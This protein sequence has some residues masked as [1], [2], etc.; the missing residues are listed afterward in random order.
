MPATKTASLYDAVESLEFY[1]DRYKKGYMNDWPA[2]K[3]RKV[4]EVIRDLPLPETGDA[5]DFG[6]GMGIFTDIIRQ[7]LPGWNLYGTD[8]S[9]VAV[10]TALERFDQCT[11]FA[12]DDPAFSGKRFDFA[13]S[14][15]VFEHVFD[16][17]EVFDELNG[18]LKPQASMLHF[19]PCGNEGSLEHR[20][21]KLRVDGIDAKL[22]NR[23]F[24]EDEGHVRRLTTDQF[25]ELCDSAG[26][27]LQREYYSNHHDGAIEWI[28]NS[29]PKLI[30]EIC[31]PSH[32]VDSDAASELAKMK[33]Y[34]LSVNLL[35]LPSQVV[36]R[37]S[38]KKYKKLQHYAM[39][40]CALPL[41][42]FSQPI[43]KRWKSK[44]REE[45]ENNRHER[46]GSEMCLYYERDG[47]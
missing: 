24:F 22:E 27:T 8:L 39:Y 3:K 35:R 19:L 38:M 41:F 28:T 23:F 6:C 43:D 45:W 17:Q 10:D 20:L 4:F 36:H 25:S 30:L 44:A 18:W 33:R 15:H 9:Q 14:H 11:F 12:P 46:N 16:L 7:A 42:V 1:E 31:D 37:F 2:E 40:A 32:A 47:R 26:F 21:C 13:F 5:L 34:L 29:S